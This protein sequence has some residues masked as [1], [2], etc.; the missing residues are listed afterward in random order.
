MVIKVFLLNFYTGTCF[1]TSKI[2]ICKYM[3]ILSLFFVPHVLPKIIFVIKNRRLA[4][5][6]TEFKLGSMY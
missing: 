5:K 6:C 4:S 3:Y 1:I 2:V